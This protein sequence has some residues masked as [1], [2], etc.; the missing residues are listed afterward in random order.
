MAVDKIVIE[1]T[2]DAKGVDKTVEQLEKVGKVDAANAAQFQKTNQQFQKG[3]SESSKAVNSHVE[4]LKSLVPAV[5]AAF[6]VQQVIAFGK[7]SLN[8]FIEAERGE[9]LLLNALNKNVEAFNRLKK[10]ASDYQNTTIYDDDTIMAAQ[11]FLATQGRTEEQINKVIKAALGLS[12]VTGENLQSSVEKLD[13]TYEGSIGRLGKLDS[14][15]K[16]LTQ[17]QLENGAAVD[18]IAEKYKGFAEAELETTAGK[19]KRLQNL[20]GEFEEA[21]GGALVNAVLPVAEGLKRAADGQQTWTDKIIASLIPGGQWL[22]LLSDIKKYFGSEEGSINQGLGEFEDAQFNAT[23]AI[24]KGYKE[25]E[26]QVR[27][28]AFLKK[29]IEDLT[30]ELSSEGKTVE[31]NKSTVKQLTAAQDE[32]NA[33]LGKT[34]N[35]IKEQKKELDKPHKGIEGVEVDIKDYELKQKEIADL[36]QAG[37][38]EETRIRE[39]TL[40]KQ[41]ALDDLLAENEKK[42]QEEVTANLEKELQLRQE[43][44]QIYIQGVEQLAGELFNIISQSE[45]TQTDAFIANLDYK[46]KAGKISDEQY[47]QQRKVFLQKQ[48]ED[49]RELAIFQ[50]VVKAALAVINAITTGDPYTAAARAAVAAAIGAAEVIAVS[51]APLP[52]FEKGGRIK[53][54]RH[55]DGGTIIEAEKDEFVIS[56]KAA[57]KIGFDNLELLN[58]GIVPVK[59]LRQ[60]ISDSR[61]KRMENT[62]KAV[63]GSND[64]DTY[65]IEKLLKK[66]IQND[67]QVAQYLVRELRGDTRKRGGLK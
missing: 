1:V 58:K 64:F 67:K 17:T 21:V 13:M 57:Q 38:D 61:E 29:L 22:N 65:N 26:K 7:A 28:Y 49:E 55:K 9:K 2:G 5:T 48:A 52:Q 12:A 19:I 14:R 32:L 47:T 43:L 40:K 8:A 20:F 46:L 45:K 66:G 56:R 62:L 37:K 6:A 15:L 31:Q 24:R 42:N 50:A 4:S 11:T 44:Q 10:A 33:I 60:G 34:T 35:S 27:N 18:L 23:E 3:I 25:N 39:E 41:L 53:G 16:G 54:K 30:K 63:F 51:S 59:L 36:A